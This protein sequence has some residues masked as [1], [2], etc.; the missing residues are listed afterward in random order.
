VSA[1][2][3][4]LLRA[5]GGTLGILESLVPSLI[6]VIVL[7]V[8]ASTDRLPVLA[9]TFSASASIVFIAIRLFRREALTQSIA[10][11]LAVVAS[12]ILTVISGKAE[13]SF[14]IGIYTNAAYA[15]AFTVSILIRWPLVGVAVG[16][17]TKRGHGWRQDRKLFRLL[18]WLTVVWIGMFGLRLVVEVPLYLSSNV[19]GLGLAKLV[20]G[21]PLYAPVVLMTW[22]FVRGMFIEESTTQA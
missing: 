2:S 1:S 4:P 6:F 8:T 21:L 12:V 15:L 13:N 3:H 16:L 9:I 11:L 22:L 5:L 18:T 14:V 17:F 7:A 20:L 19:A 10:G